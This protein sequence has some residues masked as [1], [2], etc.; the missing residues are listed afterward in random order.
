MF[1]RRQLCLRR[2]GCSI[3][4]RKTRLHWTVFGGE[5]VLH[6]CH[7]PLSA[8][9]FQATTKHRSSVL[10]QNL[11]RVFNYSSSPSFW[12]RSLKTFWMEQFSQKRLDS[13]CS[14]VASFSDSISSNHR[15]PIFCP[16]SKSILSYQSLEFPLIS[17]SFLKNDLNGA[18]KRLVI[19]NSQR[20]KNSNKNYY[21]INQCLILW[22]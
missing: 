15:T 14:Q 7:W 6:V 8:I 1:Y 4:H 16:T 21:L 13:S 2:K 19:F 5:R 9:Q 12:S 10:H 17:K 22:V 3:W 18:I 20:K 11:S